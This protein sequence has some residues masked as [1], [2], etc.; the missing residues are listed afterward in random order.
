MTI[1]LQVRKLSLGT[2]KGLAQ[3]S[4]ARIGR[5]QIGTQIT[6]SR[7][8]VLHG[9]VH[10]PASALQRE[11]RECPLGGGEEPWAG[12]QETSSLWAPLL[13]LSVALDKSLSL[14]KLQVPH[15][16]NEIDS[17]MPTALKF[18]SRGKDCGKR[19]GRGEGEGGRNWG[20]GR[21][22]VPSP[23]PTPSPSLSWT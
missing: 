12:S 16:E 14:S 5:A 23:S 20:R 22:S 9:R 10:L 6:G 2:V 21:G 3:G 15:R 1:V 18:C 13:L 4:T 11:R 17:K 7:Y 19:R 8:C